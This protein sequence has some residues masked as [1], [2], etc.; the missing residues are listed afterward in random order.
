MIHSVS[1]RAGDEMNKKLFMKECFQQY[2]CKYMVGLEEEPNPQ[3]QMCGIEHLCNMI[4]C[5]SPK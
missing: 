4:N 2:V 3:I 1:N 5:S